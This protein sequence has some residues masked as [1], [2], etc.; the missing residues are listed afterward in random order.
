MRGSSR[1]TGAVAVF[2]TSNRGKLEE[3]RIV[4][5]EF[6]I[7]VE[8]FEGGKGLEIQ[9]E[10]NA[11]VAAYASRGAARAAGGPVIVEDAGLFVDSLR[12]FPGVYSAYA[13][14]TIGVAG[15]LTLLGNNGLRGAT[16]V[17][18]LAYCAPEGEPVLFEGKVRGRVSARAAGSMGFGF[19]PIFV[20]EGG[21]ART[22]GELTT[23]EKCRVSHRGESLRRFARWYLQERS[24]RR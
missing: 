24:V 11:E 13:F 18:S 1:P 10:T 16:F 21:V 19:D 7:G 2:A 23:E 9:A 22:F 8:Q 6:G 17:S 5:R 12:G 4:L 3:A 15:V 20:P 14:K